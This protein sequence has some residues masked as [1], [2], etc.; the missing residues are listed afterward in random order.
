MFLKR[1]VLVAVLLSILVMTVSCG[2]G[3]L[4]AEA[5]EVL[6]RYDSD[7]YTVE[8]AQKGKPENFGDGG[9]EELWCVVATSP[10]GREWKFFLVRIGLAWTRISSDDRLFL[11]TECTN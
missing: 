3:G 9:N 2:G 10:D 6:N 11:M 5:L 8:S 4:P 1:L 7:D